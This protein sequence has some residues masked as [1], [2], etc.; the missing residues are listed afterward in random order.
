MLNFPRQYRRFASF[1]RGDAR[2][3][4]GHGDAR[5]VSGA[6]DAR[7]AHDV[8]GVHLGQ[9]HLQPPHYL[10]CYGVSHGGGDDDGD[11][12][13]H[14]RDGDREVS[15]CGVHGDDHG[16]DGGGPFL[17]RLGYFECPRVALA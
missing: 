4:G 12:V 17:R 16:G 9:S 5:G 3:G 15:L 13:V 7:G 1:F 8:S 10:C 2:S 14:V 6:H 11:G